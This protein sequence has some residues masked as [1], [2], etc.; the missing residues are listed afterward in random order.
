MGA[1]ASIQ[2]PPPFETVEAALMAGIPQDEIDAW[3][4]LHGGNERTMTTS[5][6]DDQHLKSSRN[7]SSKGG[8]N[9]TQK[10]DHEGG[11][12]G[13]GGSASTTPLVKTLLKEKGIIRKIVEITSVSQTLRLL[14]TC[15]ELLAAEK[16]VFENHKLPVVCDM[17]RGCNEFK[18]Y[19]AMVGTPNSRWVKW[20][21][22]SEVEE[23]SLPT[24]MTDE[25]R[26]M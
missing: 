23:L 19:R 11:S 26:Y 14:M 22:T 9:K 16:D 24:S 17:R 2:Q 6:D 15:K 3:Y 18:L 13:G 8:S 5:D 4:A 21:D 12:G 7:M 10:T 1:S 25:E 20:L